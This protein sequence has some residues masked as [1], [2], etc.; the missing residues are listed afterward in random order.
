MIRTR[1][2]KLT[3]IGI[4]AGALIACDSDDD[5]DSSVSESSDTASDTSMPVPGDSTPD[6]TLA[7]APAG[8]NGSWLLSCR[9]EDPGEIDTLYEII[10]LDIMDDVFVATASVFSDSACTELGLFSP[11]IATF[12]VVYSG[13]TETALGTATNID[14]TQEALSIPGLED[15]GSA[16]D[17]IDD[18]VILDILLV[19]NDSLFLGDDDSDDFNGFETDD[20]TEPDPEESRPTQLDQTEEFI[21]QP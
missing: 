12:S 19:M 7:G 2:S 14:L 13:T 6:S 11:A 21:R 15:P 16:E 4:L 20:S 3:L 10:Q 9:Q 1:L 5:D 8:V 18:T 17:F